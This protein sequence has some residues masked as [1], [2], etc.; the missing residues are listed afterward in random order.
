[1]KK[2]LNVSHLFCLQKVKEVS[3]VEYGRQ[4]NMN[5]EGFEEKEVFPLSAQRLGAYSR[6]MRCLLTSH[7]SWP[8]LSLHFSSSPDH[9]HQ[10]LSSP[11]PT[12]AKPP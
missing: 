7:I 9:D 1:M 4:K 5:D 6:V 12:L 2:A 11:C 10:S 3:D 8:G